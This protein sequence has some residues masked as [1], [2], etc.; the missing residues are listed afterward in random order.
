MS[1]F[2]LYA[3]NETSSLPVNG[4]TWKRTAI[5]HNGNKVG[6]TSEESDNF[7][8]RVKNNT[9]VVNGETL[10]TSSTN[11]PKVSTDGSEFGN[12]NLVGH[13][14]CINITLENYNKLLNGETVAG[15]KAHDPDAIYNIVTNPA[16]A[17]TVYCDSPID[18]S[19]PLYNNQPECQMP[20]HTLTNA[21]FT[22]MDAPH[23]SVHGYKFE[24]IPG[25]QIE[26]TY[27]VD[28]RT[29]DFINRLTRGETFTTIVRD[30]YGNR[31]YKNTTYAGVFKVTLAPFANNGVNITG[32]TWFSIECID[33]RGVGSIVLYYDVLIRDTVVEKLYEMQENDLDHYHIEYNNDDPIVGYKN[34][35][36]FTKLFADTA[37][38]DEN[39]TGILLYNPGGDKTYY[40]D[41]HKNRSKVNG[42][43]YFGSRYYHLYR[44][45]SYQTTNSEGKTVTVHALDDTATQDIVEGGTVTIDGTV[46]QVNEDPLLFCKHDGANLHRVGGT[47]SDKNKIRVHWKEDPYGT[48]DPSIHKY[49]G[50]SY[51]ERPL[52]VFNLQPV[53][54]AYGW[55]TSLMNPTLRAKL[56]DGWYYAVDD[57]YNRDLSGDSMKF[58]DH[59]TVDMNGIVFQ[60]ITCTDLR[61]FCIID[62]DNNNDTHIRNGVL[63]G[64]YDQ[65][66]MQMFVD[67]SLSLGIF[68]PGGVFEGGRNTKIAS[69]KFCSVENVES[70]Y[71]CG[72][73]GSVDVGGVYN[74][75]EN[76]ILNTVG[77]INYKGNSYQPGVIAPLDA[78]LNPEIGE[79]GSIKLVKSSNIYSLNGNNNI[80][81]RIFNMQYNCG[82]QHEFFFHFYD[83][84]SA[85]ISTVKTAL[86]SVVKCPAG[87]EFV[88][89]SAYGMVDKNGKLVKDSTWLNT[90]KFVPFEKLVLAYYVPATCCSYVNCYWHDTR[91]IAFHVCDGKSFLFDSCRFYRIANIHYTGGNWFVTHLLGDIEEDWRYLD[92]LVMNN[93]EAVEGPDWWSNGANAGTRA[94]SITGLQSFTFT[95]NRGFSYSEGTIQSCLAMNNYYCGLK[96]TRNY[97]FEHPLFFYKNNVI[98]RAGY[99]P[100]TVTVGGFRPY[101]NI[102]TNLQYHSK[103]THNNETVDYPLRYNRCDDPVCLDI[104]MRDTFAYRSDSGTS[105]ENYKYHRT[106]LNNDIYK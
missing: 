37:D 98:D 31:L 82:K 30:S 3:V 70:R 23:I 95:N 103:T 102:N 38:S 13:G 76:V 27:M 78:E 6:I 79:G 64:I 24:F 18:I 58:P 26:L 2:G 62:I 32:E 56:P 28:T 11:N 39:Y 16:T 91:T 93:C 99:P 61:E 21:T 74:I 106:R 101:E 75:T 46:Y 49:V 72:Y 51:S 63:S 96:I 19:D 100:Q 60:G 77:V 9:L 22:Q 8:T 52:H 7:G 54:D 89:I 5:M 50:T 25:E 88:K 17:Q 73:E 83:A 90:N 40:I 104:A 86:F 71:T 66:N 35:V 59:F 29:G 69:S 10:A 80:M 47:G 87:A 92:N 41:Y 48:I 34:K 94:I 42:Q 67:S 53:K 12:V 4:T 45:Y 1:N 33:S 84:N 68:S 20:E 105:T 15:Y 14:K 43:Y 57:D 36:G 65:H 81:L 97:K 44:K 55:G 85:F